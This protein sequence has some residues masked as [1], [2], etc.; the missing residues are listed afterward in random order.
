MFM[1]YRGG[2]IG[3]KYMHEIETRYENMSLERIHRNGNPKPSQSGADATSAR[4]PQPRPESPVEDQ[5]SD[6]NNNETG[7]DNGGR[8]V[9]DDMGRGELTRDE[10]DGDYA[11]SETGDESD[12]GRSVDSDMIGSDD[13]YE[14]YGLADF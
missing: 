2:S 13:G 7:L 11:P 1:R 5:E 14:S 4:A 6:N 3:H 10:S 8:G 12:D 9:S